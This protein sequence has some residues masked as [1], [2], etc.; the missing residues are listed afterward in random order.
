M[1]LC[2]LFLCSVLCADPVPFEKAAED[3]V[4]A[5]RF[6]NEWRLCPATSGNISV[7]VEPELV[8]I[9][10]SGKHKGELTTDDILLVDLEGKVQNSSK[11]PSAETLLH[12]SL[13]ALF[14]DVGAV[15]HNHSLNGT[16]LTLRNS[17]ADTLVTEG[18]EIHKALRG[19]T[20]HESTVNIPIFENSQDMVALAAEVV[21]YLKTHPQTYGYLIRG[22]G[23][24]TWGKDMKEAK[25]RVEAFEYIFECE[26]R[27]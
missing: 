14:P 6:L 15:L 1:K 2:V 16:L 12:T 8:A 23:F 9:T 20:T 5:G 17:T 7:R 27:R 26:L 18:Y 24:Y 4:N 11:K 3:I 21:A 13:Y 19:I 25:I 22:H 10:A